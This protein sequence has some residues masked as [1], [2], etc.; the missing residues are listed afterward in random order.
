MHKHTCVSTQLMVLI[1]LQSWQGIF[2]VNNETYECVALIVISNYQICSVVR[3][4]A[5]FDQLSKCWHHI[6]KREKKKLGATSVSD[7]SV[8]PVMLQA[9]KAQCVYNVS[10]FWLVVYLPPILLLKSVKE[11]GKM[12][13]LGSCTNDMLCWKVYIFWKWNQKGFC[14]KWY[15]HQKTIRLFLCTPCTSP[16]IYVSK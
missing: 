4:S 11:K 13:L 16:F 10:S 14:H 7:W 12:W 1:W 8:F 15:K 6:G 9:P 5:A 3:S 2:E